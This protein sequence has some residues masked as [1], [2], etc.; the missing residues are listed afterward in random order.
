[1]GVMDGV[2][3]KGQR[4]LTKQERLDAAVAKVEEKMKKLEV[5]LATKV[6]AVH[7]KLI[8]EYEDHIQF[9]SDVAT[10]KHKEAMMA[11]RIKCAELLIKRVDELKEALEMEEISGEDL[12]DDEVDEGLVDKDGNNNIIS[13]D[14]QSV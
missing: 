5:V 10:G 3:K 11:N 13:F 4:G 9:L 1:M 12:K 6:T 7:E 14:I 8:Q 2:R